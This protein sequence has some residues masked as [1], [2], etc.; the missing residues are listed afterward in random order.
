M[1]TNI[2]QL[3]HIAATLNCEHARM[4]TAPTRWIFDQ[5]HSRKPLPTESASV[6]NQKTQYAYCEV[7]MPQ[8]LAMLKDPEGIP[9]A[10]GRA[11]GAIEAEAIAK[12][13]LEAYRDAKRTG[14]DHY[15]ATA[16]YTLECHTVEEWEA[17]TG[18]WR[19]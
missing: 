3:I 17:I 10:W 11:P 19:H 4:T 6:K 16:K 2:S 13:E 18:N 7:L 15:L 5:V 8:Y 12:I 9:R 14:G 1:T